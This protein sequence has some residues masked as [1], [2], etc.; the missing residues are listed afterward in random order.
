MR[1][2]AV[3][4]L[5]L[6]SCT[7]LEA[8]AWE[9]TL[10]GLPVPPTALARQSEYSRGLV[11]K[12]PVEKLKAN[13]LKDSS[14]ITITTRVAKT[15]SG[16]DLLWEL[17]WEPG[18]AWGPGTWVAFRDGLGRI[19]ELRIILLEGTDSADHKIAQPGTWLRLVPQ[20][21]GRGCRL[22][23]FLAGR[24]VTGGWSVSASLTEVLES[25][26][27]WLWEA[28]AEELDW[29]GMLPLH[30]WEDEKVEALQARMHK[31]LSTVPEGGGTLWW[32]DPKSSLTGTSAS[33]APWGS[34]TLLP[35]SGGHAIRGL[36]T[37]GVTL[38]TATGILRG[39]KAPF[40]SWEAL[41][42]P[43]FE[44]PG[45]SR[46]LVPTDLA[47]DPAFAFDWIRNLG[48]AVYRTLYPSR[49]LTDESADVKDVPF[50][51]PI[52]GAGFAVQDF[53]AL[54]HLLAVT[55]PGQIYLASLSLQTNSEKGASA[56]VSFSKP[57]VL[58]P[59]IGTDHRVRVAIYA[60][61]KEMT[62]DQWIAQIPERTG[63]RPGHL[64]LTALPLP[65]TVEFPVL[66]AR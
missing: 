2:W 18:V 66:P 15:G 42:E 25:P 48:L 3:S 51:D 8:Q 49:P 50:M 7:F 20:T 5:V 31:L 14:G 61:P 60:G 59:W 34:W 10:E 65:P 4:F 13:V 27:S 64:A 40:P 19:R 29:N 6:F 44:L 33:G 1:G 24:L 12:L 57:V 63:V 47:D 58:I 17:R 16:E 55:K 38:W 23:V 46:A 28:T 43:R 30:R 35:G 45:Y 26:D 11:S 32:P 39:W 52:P 62:W 36:G 56:G 22:D 41:L 9:G 53:P 54:I 37:W 21:Q